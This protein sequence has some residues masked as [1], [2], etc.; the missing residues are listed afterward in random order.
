MTELQELINKLN[1]INWTTYNDNTF[2]TDAGDWKL[3]WKIELTDGVLTNVCQLII[4]VIYHDSIVSS[5]GCIDETDTKTIGT[6]IKSTQSK[7]QN[8]EWDNKSAIQD[9]GK[10]IWNS[11]SS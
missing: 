2:A 6:W 3:H 9:V 8:K 4:R 1:A 10:S 11:L 5:W 7:I